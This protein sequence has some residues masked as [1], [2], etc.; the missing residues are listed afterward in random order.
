M[1]MK[2]ENENNRTGCPSE[3]EEQR[4][5]TPEEREDLA[6]LHRQ[7]VN[8]YGVRVDPNDPF[9]IR[10]QENGGPYENQAGRDPG[11]AAG[12][13]FG[14][15]REYGNIAVPVIAVAT[16]LIYLAAAKFHLF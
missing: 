8:L 2:E 3:T 16:F 5:L 1:D 10:E 7:N 14:L 15:F 4:E 13:F 9:G 11:K 12:T 6:R